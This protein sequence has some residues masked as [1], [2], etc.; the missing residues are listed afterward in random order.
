M[1]V[2]VV[3][4]TYWRRDDSTVK[5]LHK[6]FLNLCAQT[7]TQFKVFIVGDHYAKE[8][9]L[10]DVVKQYS[11]RLDIYCKNN[12][13]SLRKGYFTIRANLWTC[14]GILARYAALKQA[15]REDYDV[16]LHLDDDDIWLPNH[17]KNYVNVFRQFPLV[18]FVFSKAQYKQTYLP[19]NVP[20]GLAIGMNNLKGAVRPANIV[21][22]SFGF[23]LK[24]CGGLLDTLFTNRIATINQ[25]KN[26]RIKETRLEPFDAVQLK[27]LQPRKCICIPQIT[28]RKLSDVNIP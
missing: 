2:A 19:H 27:A 11:N 23:N 1:K 10:F 24:T 18:D 14:G 9:E 16:Y 21:H 6:M 17:I 4:A 3:I 7:H 15:I 12:P 22:S 5:H 8:Q 20:A 25:I 13:T 28:C 26:K